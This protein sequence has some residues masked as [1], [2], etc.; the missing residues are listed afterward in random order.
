MTEEEL[1]A[2]EEQKKLEEANKGKN[3]ELSEAEALKK[4]KEE[5]DKLKSRNSQLEAAKKEYYDALLNDGELKEKDSKPKYRSSSEIREEWK[6]TASNNTNLRNAQ[7]SV[8]YDEAITREA[9]KSERAVGMSYLPKGVDEKGNVIIPTPDE[10]DRAKRT[11][12][13]LKACIMQSSTEDKPVDEETLT[14]GDPKLFNMALAGK[15]L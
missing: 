3:P 7:L 1:K 6:K 14:G 11:H 8:E 12:D 5:N 2:Q 10:K 15:G 13:F 4:L 9:P